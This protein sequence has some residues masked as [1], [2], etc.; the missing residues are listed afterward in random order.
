MLRIV[1]LAILIPLA[2]PLA[3]QEPAKEK[4]FRGQDAQRVAAW[5]QV[6]RDHAADYRLTLQDKPYAPLKMLPQAVFRHSQPVR[7]DDIGADHRRSHDD[8]RWLADDQLRRP[9][10]LRR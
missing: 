2:L 3:A 5:L 4:E 7:G 10:D 6:S 9:D 8:W 1:T